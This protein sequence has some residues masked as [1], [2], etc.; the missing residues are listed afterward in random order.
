MPRAYRV[1]PQF[2]HDRAIAAA[3]SRTGPDYHLRKLAALLPSLT[4]EQR[5]QLAELALTALAP[6]PAGDGAA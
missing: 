6:E 5:S 2:A 1:D 3:R 4:A